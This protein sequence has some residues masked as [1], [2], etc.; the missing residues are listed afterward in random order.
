VF[1]HGSHIGSH[2][3]RKR[4]IYHYRRRLPVPY[5]GEVTLSLKTR[6][7]REAEHL[8]AILDVGFGR[9]WDYSLMS[10]DGTAGGQDKVKAVDFR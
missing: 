6:R 2:I 3:A 1:P 8:A 4:G 5:S 9:A 7:F 10:T